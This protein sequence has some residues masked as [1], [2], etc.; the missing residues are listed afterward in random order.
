MVWGGPGHHHKE[1]E[2]IFTLGIIFSNPNAKPNP[3]SNP[4]PNPCRF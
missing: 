1:L 2:R 3:T 4:N